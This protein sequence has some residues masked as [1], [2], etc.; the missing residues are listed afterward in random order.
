MDNAQDVIII[1]A[2]GEKTIEMPVGA[3]RVAVQ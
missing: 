1:H 2:A 3:W